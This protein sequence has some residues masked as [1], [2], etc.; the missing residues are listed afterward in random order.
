MV[1][2]ALA[3]AAGTVEVRVMDVQSTVAEL[4]VLFSR[5]FVPSLIVCKD[6]AA[7][8]ATVRGG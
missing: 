4:V 1:G 7:L 3:A 8:G 6:A 2:G 5:S